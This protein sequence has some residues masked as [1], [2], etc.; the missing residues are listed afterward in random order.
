MVK[1]EKLKERQNLDHLVL[2]YNSPSVVFIVF[3]E[4]V[5]IIIIFKIVKSPTLFEILLP[6]INFYKFYDD[7]A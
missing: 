3:W 7:F 5:I 6:F 2:D 1:E 4:K